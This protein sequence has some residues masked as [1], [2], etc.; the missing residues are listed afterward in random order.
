MWFFKKRPAPP[1]VAKP[2]TTTVWFISNG[3][4]DKCA[5]THVDALT[6]QQRKDLM[7]ASHFKPFTFSGNYGLAILSPDRVVYVTSTK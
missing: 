5:W 3:K 6:E 7:D 4:E 2:Y 1:V